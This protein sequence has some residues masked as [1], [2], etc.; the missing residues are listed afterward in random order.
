LRREKYDLVS[1]ADVAGS[2]AGTNSGTGRPRIA[3]TLDDGYSDFVTEA[4]PILA[5][6]DCPITVFLAT[7]VI[8][9][10]CWYW[11]DQVTF[12]FSETGETRLRM[13]LGSGEVTYA[14]NNERERYNARGHLIE[15]LKTVAEPER[16]DALGRIGEALSVDIPPAP[17]EAYST[18]TWDDVRRCAGTGLV[19]FGPHSMTHPPLDTISAEHSRSEINGSWK[20]LNE[21]G[22][23]VVP[24]FCYPF[25]A[26]GPREIE[27]LAQSEMLGAV[28]TEYRYASARPF[29]S[30]HG[31]RRFTVPR[32]SYDEGD[33]PF[34]QAVTG[35]ERV[36]LGFRKGA[37]GWSVAG[38]P[39][40]IS[41]RGSE[42]F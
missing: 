27:I 28:T 3:F 37:K 32:I 12:A 24:I 9:R 42:V 11:Y 35:V 4:M 19:T 41:A 20:R 8:D 38:A 26:Y 31:D 30:Q 17:T 18:M 29:D 21:A 25:G 2:Q 34:L 39:P 14:W 6:F 10:K 5:E 15:R 23:G 33:F 1:L 22:A 40:E 36:K 13:A 7:S 16:V